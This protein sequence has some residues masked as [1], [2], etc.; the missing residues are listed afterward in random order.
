MKPIINI[1]FL[2]TV[3]I[4]VSC[5]KRDDY[6]VVVPYSNVLLD[7]PGEGGLWDL[8][9]EEVQEYTFSWKEYE[10]GKEYTLIFSKDE[11]LKKVV[12]VKV[13]ATD[14]Y[15][16][17]MLDLN[18]Y[19]ALLGIGG[20]K[21]GTIYW[22]VKETQKM[23]AAASE[24]RTLTVNRVRT[25]LKLPEDQAIVT[26]DSDH[27][28]DKVTFGWDT[29]EEENGDTYEL[30][31][32]LDQEGDQGITIP[33][34]GAA[35]GMA[36]VTQRQI[37]DA[38]IQLPIA[39]FST[40]QVLWNLVN[41][42]KNKK[43]SLI[44]SV[45]NL[46]DMLELKDVR[47]GETIVYKVAKTTYSDGNTVVWLAE[48]LRTTK[49]PDGTEMSLANGEYWNAPSNL[50]EELQQANG[51]C[52][53]LGIRERIAPE[54][55]R[56][57]T[58]AEYEKLLSEALKSSYGANAIRHEKYWVN[59]SPQN[60]NAWGIGLVPAGCVS[61]SGSS[62]S[63]SGNNTGDNNCYLLIGDSSD[64]VALLSNWGMNNDRKVYNSTIY[65]GAPAR[66]IY[67]G[68]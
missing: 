19:M 24:I 6:Q 16:M 66:L 7:S 40:N 59:V 22:T 9:N 23:T 54:G 68:K 47:G 30:L 61:A 39:K 28:N 38:V 55:W 13:G 21:A 2:A 53:S 57:P 14:T 33:L 20:G 63:V 8:N 62:A 36:T 10:E 51:K 50:S 52:Y 64:S 56:L 29:N 15:V 3:L 35:D 31:L 44:A 46:S 4:L 37:Q 49:F 42:T 32:S 25:A 27:G 12:T 45:M 18:S 48:N 65:G 17:K 11:L 41:V 26:L 43:V 58:F 1:L 60:A 34:P 5:N 67:V